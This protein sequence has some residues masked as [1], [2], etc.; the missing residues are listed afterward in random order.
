LIPGILE[1][2]PATQAVLLA[3]GHIQLG[4]IGIEGQSVDETSDGYALDQVHFAGIGISLPETNATI[5]R[6]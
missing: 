3:G 1:S 4:A 5:T 6:A 2:P